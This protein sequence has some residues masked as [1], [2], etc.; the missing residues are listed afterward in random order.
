[1]RRILRFTAIGCGCLV[2]L[3][4]FISMVGALIGG[5][6]TSSPP[7]RTEKTTEE[8]GRYD[9][10]TTVIEAVDGDT[11]KIEPAV[12]GEDEVR[13]IGVDAPET[14]DPDEGEEP[15]GKEASI[16]TSVELEGEKVELEFDK[17]KKD[18][19]GRLLAYVYP[20]GEEMFNEELL[21]GGYAQVYTVQPNTKYKDRFEEAQDEAR[22]QDLEIWGGIWGLSK[23]EQCEL[24]NHGN[25]IG[26]D[27]PGCRAADWQMN[28][29]SGQ[30]IDSSGNN[31]NGTPTD[32]VQTGST[33]VFNG[34]SSRVVVA[35][36]DSLDPA[37]W[38]I[39]LTASVRVRGT[40]LDDDSYDIV[41]KGLSTTTGGDYKM[42]IKRVKSD[43]TVG[44]LHCL[45]KGTE[46]TVRKVARRDIVDEGWHTFECKKTSTSV[47]A[48]VDGKSY[49]KTGSVG[50]ISN[51]RE[52]I[53]GAKTT[54]PLDDVF[55]GSMDFV[56][57]DS[58]Q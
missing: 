47:V 9:A 54:S 28:E 37:A 41:R 51:S 26:E 31:N 24:A 35:D 36:N 57:I 56:S 7:E 3:G 44:K 19:Y 55:D 48:R 49:T 11:V 10:V 45:F 25:G 4:I 42:E 29:T 38:D 43:P 8:S 33:Y 12:D 2:G 13:L 40:S 17:D 16:Y 50:S 20:M 34:S 27:S 58:A 1:M 39:T 15:Y 23:Q 46:G 14:K 18:H 53:V 22:E 5:G 30:M 21:E 32:V 6:C 52:V